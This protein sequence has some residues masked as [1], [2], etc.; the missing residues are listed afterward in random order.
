MNTEP[1]ARAIPRTD[2]AF[3]ILFL[4]FYVA[5]LV[6]GTEDMPLLADNQHY[7]FIAERAASG[8]PP[9]ISQFD[10]KNALGMLI[11]AGAINVGRAIGVD[12][13]VASRIASVLAGSIAIGLLWPLARAIAGSATAALVAVVGMLSL[14]RFAAMSAMGSQPKIFLVA[15]LEAS[16]LCVS[17]ARPL[18]AGMTAAAAFLCWQPAGVM[19]AAG[20]LA[21]LAERGGLRRACVF[22]LAALVPIIFYETYFVYHDAIPE[23]IEQALV[24]PA[25]YM[26]SLPHSLRPILRRGSWVFAVAQ[27]IDASSFVPLAAL[28]ALVVFWSQ[29]FRRH[30][31]VARAFYGRADRIYFVLVAHAALL[32]CFISFQGFPD[33]FWL[34]PLMAIAAGWLVAALADRLSLWVARLPWHRVAQAACAVA[35][36]TMLVAGRWD[37]RE[38]NGLAAQRQAAEALGEILQ[39]GYSVYAVGCTH[40]LALNHASNFSPFGFYFRGVADYLHAKTHG[41][42]YVPLRD[43]KLPDVILVSRGTYLG[44]QPWFETEYMRSRRTEFSS[45]MVQIWLHSRRGAT[46]ISQDSRES[47]DAPR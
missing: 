13:V 36:A 15:F 19:L 18:L 23:Q 38:M 6:F 46:R 3:G 28:V 34:D 42:G 40:L 39:A 14:E 31:P 1:R 21:L 43:G 41:R 22:V 16:L 17:Y 35:L 37:F 4:L 25:R 10:P 32:C 27:G 20:P 47:E 24:F 33:R 29:I 7:F 9:H 30:T 11:T 12:D 5:V 45:Q 2:L 8:V 44:N 26:D